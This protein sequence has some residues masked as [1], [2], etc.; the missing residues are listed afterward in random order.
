MDNLHVGKA[1]KALDMAGYVDDH[2][3]DVTIT[4]CA[5]DTVTG[6]DTVRY[7][8]GLV[9]TNVTENGKPVTG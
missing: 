3:T 6:T 1:A 4:D 7:V 2:I 8:D 5:F 9:L